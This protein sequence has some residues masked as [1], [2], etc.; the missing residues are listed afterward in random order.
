MFND[1]QSNSTISS[2]LIEKYKGEAPRYTSYPTAPNFSERYT[3]A[4]YAKHAQQSNQ[5]LVPRDLSL[6][7]HI[8]FC[9][10]L[11]YF[12]GCNKVITQC[13]NNKVENYVEM[14]LRE[15]TLRSKLFDHDRQVTQIHFGGGTPNFLSHSRLQHILDRVANCFN[16][17]SPP[18]IEV[19]IE[20]DPRVIDANG[21][22][23]LAEIG[24][25]RFSI[26]V[27]DFSHEVQLAVNREQPERATLNIIAAARAISNSVNVDL[28]SGLPK[29]TTE[30]FR[31]TIKKVIESGVTRVAAYKFAYLPER[32][33][34]QKMID[35]SVLPNAKQRTL[36]D[37]VARESFTNAGY[38][39][40]GMDHFASANDSLSLALKNNTLQRNFQGY[41]TNANTDLIG[42]GASAIS[43]FNN[44]FAQNS[45][46]LSNY[47]TA[48]KNHILPIQKGYSL[49]NDD[50][51]RAELI[52]Q[53]MCRNSIDLST[54]LQKFID[55]SS[56]LCLRDYFFNELESLQPFIED[57]L[58]T[59]NEYH[60]EFSEQASYFR[61]QIAACFDIHLQKNK[62]IATSNRSNI[63]KFS[64][65]L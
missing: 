18:H 46:T 30:S 43:Q 25:N 16:L 45:V 6:Y 44:A 24:F 29:Q 58:I 31:R 61:R 64:Q 47:N 27:Q 23:E 33:K 63:I 11:C 41:T 37:E 22:R 48:L 2:S 21:I 53:I 19:G 3:V 40:I 65:T 57:R 51:L 12:C 28:I 14:V 38:M 60:I 17:V 5:S 52:Q 8:P 59:I 20:V 39:H 36:L 10:S 9:H 49:S 50:I 13:G 1:S 7:I 56:Q 34:A 35:P 42:I 54:K 62:D 15:I 4:N 32:I 55:V 26:G